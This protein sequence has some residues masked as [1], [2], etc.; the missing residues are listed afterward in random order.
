MSSTSANPHPI[1]NAELQYK[2][3]QDLIT[4]LR[5]QESLERIPV[6]KASDNL[7]I[8]CREQVD[9]LIGSEDRNSA[10]VGV[11][12]F[13]KKSLKKKRFLCF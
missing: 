1:S 11:N 4:A 13:V 10:A 7:I 12:P 2:R 9:P 5:Y 3:L 8:Y 6:S